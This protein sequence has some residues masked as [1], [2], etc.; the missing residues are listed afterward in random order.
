MLNRLRAK[1][2]PEPNPLIVSEPSASFSNERAANLPAATDES[3]T[4]S[5][6]FARIKPRSRPGYRW[7]LRPLGLPLNV[8][9]EGAQ[10]TVTNPSKTGPVWG[11]SLAPQSVH[12]AGSSP[13]VA[14]GGG[15]FS[16]LPISRRFS[17]STGLSM[18][19]QTLG[20]TESGPIIALS[21]PHLV[22]TDIRLT[23][24]DVPIN[25]RFRPKGSSEMGFYIEAGFS[26]L[27]FLNERYAE[28][29]EQQKEVVVLVMGTNGQEQ[30]VTQYVTE[31][32][33]VNHSEPAF[34]RIYW[35]RL[36]NFSIGVER[37]MGS[38]FRL[39]AEP[40]LKYPIGPFTRENLMLGS[41][42]ISLRLGF[43][44]GR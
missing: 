7:S 43:Q 35:G 9:V 31:Q 8:Q 30:T 23:T 5:G 21:S 14:L 16:E 6:S 40:Y 24:I 12:A 19:R 20:T 26:S 17:L 4:S 15:L 29:Y 1:S 18:A 42:G 22:S 44:A 34:G 41:G 33:I 28:T 37:R 36:L 11:V 25:L 27:A 3:A 2:A 13:A 39:S 10:V 38:Q 32:Q